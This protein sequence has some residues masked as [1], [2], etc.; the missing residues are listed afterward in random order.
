M[1]H[2]WY[3]DTCGFRT[4]H[5][6]SDSVDPD[7]RVEKAPDVCLMRG[8]AE[9]PVRLAAGRAMHPLRCFLPLIDVGLR[10]MLMAVSTTTRVNFADSALY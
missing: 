1:R 7:L 6:F 5:A 8:Q 4:S 2:C 10:Q 3:V 9:I